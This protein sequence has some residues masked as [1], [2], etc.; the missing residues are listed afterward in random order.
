MKNILKITL[1]VIISYSCNNINS[2]SEIEGL[3][4]STE[5]TSPKFSSG[6]QKA[7]IQFNHN[8]N[9]ELEARGIFLWNGEYGYEW[10]LEKV[11]YDETTHTL[12]IN[13]AD[14]DTYIG[15]FD[16]KN[17]RIYGAVHL[18]DAEPGNQNDS[19]NLIPADKNLETKLL[20]PRVSDKNGKLDYSYSAPEQLED[21]LQTE[22]INDNNNINSDSLIS[23]INKIIG[24]E[25]GRIESLL[26]LKDYKL[27]V[28]E[29]FYGYD[30]TQL[31]KIHSCTKS[32]T[33]LLLGISLNNHNNVNVEQSIFNFFPEY[34]SL[35]NEEN[36]II[37]LKNTLTMTAGFQWDEYPKEMY[38]TND[39]FQ[40]ILTRP[41]ES[42]PGKKFTYNSGCSILLGGV[43]N[44]LEHKYAQFYAEEVLFGPLGI[45]EYT[46]ETHK[47]G[48]P[49][50]GGGLQLLPRNMA[51]IGLLVLNNGK[52]Q[53]KQI[54]PE[55]WIYESTIPHTSESD[56]FDY[57]YQWW[58]RSKN[59]KQWWNETETTDEFDM[60]VALGWGGQRIIIVKELNL[61]VV[62]TG[63]N[64]ENNMEPST[65]PMVIEKII[66]AIINNK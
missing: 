48:A 19:L 17:K 55:E 13:D 31:H 11:Q 14:G 52:W 32:I 65:F 41:M 12:T 37:T 66:P 26:I 25:Y 2:K 18:K 15:V 56:Y 36:E 45:S 6:I 61:V 57:G 54:I 62:T 49:Q 16:Y 30:R 35:K 44:F 10:R 38:E 46:W 29:Y 28:E 43:I 7:V 63:S 23:L 58:L 59:T 8:Q 22:S 20:Y 4:I 64:Y 34:N 60:I 24:Q 33:S 42:N 9:G 27:M 47:N 40:Y 51:K 39:W 1:L 5:E 3:W 21:G 53:D 50:C